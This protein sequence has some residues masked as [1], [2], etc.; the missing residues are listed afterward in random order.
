MTLQ[1]LVDYFDTHLEQQEKINAN[2]SKYWNMELDEMIEEL[3]KSIIY[4]IEQMIDT[5]S[6][7]YKGNTPEKISVWLMGKKNPLLVRKG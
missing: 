6:L 7:S 1:E 5:C 2:R 3:G 4:R